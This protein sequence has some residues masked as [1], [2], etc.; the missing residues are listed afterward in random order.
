MSPYLQ[1]FDR[2]A[3]GNFRQ[4]MQEITLNAA[5]GAYLNMAGNN[6]AAPNENY[7]REVLQLFTIGLVELNTDGSVVTDAQGNPVPSYTQAT[8]NAFA[9]VFTGWNF[10]APLMTGV[11]NYGS[12][13]EFDRRPILSG[14]LENEDFGPGCSHTLSFQKQVAEVLVASTTA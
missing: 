4:L 11:P 1:T 2:N 7:A 12:A 13:Q 8:V 3:F 14:F 10:A 6:K 5:M 9:R